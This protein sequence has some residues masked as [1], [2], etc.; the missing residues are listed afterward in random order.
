MM[1]ILEW[2]NYNKKVEDF[3]NTEYI[4]IYSQPLTENECKE[5][6]TFVHVGEIISYDD[7]VKAET[8]IIN[9]FIDIFNKKPV[10]YYKKEIHKEIEFLKYIKVV[11]NG[12]REY[13]LDSVILLDKDKIAFYIDYDLNVVINYYQ[14]KPDWIDT[15]VKKHGLFVLK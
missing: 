5:M 10:V 3:P 15:I 13:D 1:K 8:K 12:C 7:Y 14:K 4:S 9:F 6:I 2:Y 11:S